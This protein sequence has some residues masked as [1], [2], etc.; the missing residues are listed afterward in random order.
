MS[1]FYGGGSKPWVH[2]NCAGDL[3]ELLRVPLRNQGYCGVGRGLSGLHWV[4]CNGRGPHL[5]L[6]QEPQ[7]SST[8]LTWIAGSLQ[9]WDRRVRLRLV[10]RNGIPTDSRVV[11]RVT[12]NLSS[13]MW[14][15]RVFPYDAQV[16]QGPFVLC[17]HPQG[18]IHRGVRASGAYQERTGKS[19]PFGMWHHP[20]GYVSNFLVR[21][22][23]S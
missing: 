13:C 9:S 12:D 20:R 5:E 8:F 3:R 10:L 6:R 16:C 7:G 18:C 15:L 4:W 19:G 1:S 23:S 11:H 21:P 22:A 17:L 14:N 2:S